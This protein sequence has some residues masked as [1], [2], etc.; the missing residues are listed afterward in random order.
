MNADELIEKLSLERHPEGGWYRQTYRAAENVQTAGGARAASTAIYFLL[1]E[2]EIS[3]LHRI[4]SDE[5]WHFHLGSPLQVEAITPEGQLES[6]LLGSDLAAGEALQA[7]VPAGRWFG[8]SLP[9][10]GWSL[11]GCTVAPGFDFADFEMGR[12]DQLLSEFPA[13]TELI[14]K[15]T[16]PAPIA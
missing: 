2:N 1:R 9:R 6:F 10:G 14:L 4:A 8:A 15:L 11:V 12:R 7:W 3:A 5:V 16:H 13:C